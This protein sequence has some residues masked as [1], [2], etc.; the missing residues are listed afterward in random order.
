LNTWL[1]GTIDWRHRQCRVRRAK[2]R[3]QCYPWPHPL[4]AKLEFVWRSFLPPKPPSY[5]DTSGDI[6]A[7]HQ[8]VEFSHATNRNGNHR[9]GSWGARETNVDSQPLFRVA[10]NLKIECPPRLLPQNAE[11]FTH[12]CPCRIPK[13]WATFEEES[14]IRRFGAP[15]RR[16]GSASFGGFRTS[17]AGG[18]P[19]DANRRSVLNG[20]HLKQHRA[21]GLYSSEQLPWHW[22][23]SLC[24]SPVSLRR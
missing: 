8:A 4:R 13:A 21:S 7:T 1:H 11:A 23:D 24:T 12:L 19:Q 10:G 2:A 22:L 20:L 17:S 6:V 18:T 14:A 5:H 9:R 16:P 15:V 3:R